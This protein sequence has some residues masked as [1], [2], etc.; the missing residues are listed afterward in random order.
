[1]TFTT[2]LSVATICLMGAM[3]PGPSLAVVV[4]RTVRNSRTHG[5]ATA[6]AHAAGVGCYALLTTLG[7]AVVVADNEIVYRG[8]AFAGA[9]Y[10]LLLGVRALRASGGVRL[11]AGDASAATLA[12][13][14]RDGFLI[15]FLN[16][17][18][19]VFFLALFSQFVRPGMPL[20]EHV[21]LSLT[22]T[23]IDGGWYAF[24]ALALSRSAI[25]EWLRR[26]AHW[27]DRLTGVLLVALAG[28]TVWRLLVSR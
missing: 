22:A 26:R 15:A 21:L 17:K 2:W 12:R 14:A 10:L 28:V 4:R 27:I 19:A 23:V 9:A 25:L 18:I 7:L 13:A 8:L 1:M 3:S 16:P 24:V 20:G 11:D 6:L 5:L